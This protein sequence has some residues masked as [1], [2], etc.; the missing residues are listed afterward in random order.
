[1][2][3]LTQQQRENFMRSVGATFSQSG[4]VRPVEIAA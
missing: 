4:G 1:L 2:D 3:D